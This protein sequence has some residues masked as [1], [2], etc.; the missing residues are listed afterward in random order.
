[1]SSYTI[2]DRDLKRSLNLNIYAITFGMV[3]FTI[4][5][6]PI[7]SPV[8]TG[9]M[10]K[11]GAGDFIYSVVLALP[12][13]GAIS[14]I[15]GS[16]LLET[17]G[18][19]KFV[20]L[21]SGFVHRFLWIPVAI[22]PLLLDGNSHQ[23]MIWSITILITVSS[24]ASSVT[25]VAFN[26]WM[27]AL[28]PPD[29]VGRFFGMRTLISTISGAA[30][31]LIVGLF[32]DRIDNLFGF[33]IVFAVGALFGLMDIIT[34]SFIKHPPMELS[35]DKPSLIKIITEP[36]KNKN[37]LNYVIFATA[38]SFG[39]NFTAPFFNVYMLEDLKMNYFAINLA[40]QVMSSLTTI[41]FVRQWGV[42]A[43]RYGNKPVTFVSGLI[44]ALLPLMW[45]FTSP[46]NITMVF[47]ANIFTGI[48]WSGYNL[49]LFNQS[50]WL[51][52]ERNRSSYIACFTLL[53]SVVGTAAAYVCGGTFMQFGRPFFEKAHIPF[54]MGTTLSAFFIMCI[55]SSILR[56]LALAIFHQLYN[57]ENSKSSKEMLLDIISQLKK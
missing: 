46:S 26:S 17:T 13:L 2:S 28:V 12:L 15:F 37:Y 55:I 5:G 36:F 45:I 54:L 20:F 52:P 22:I 10:R 39:V 31:A 41:L 8:F 21:A 29:I 53:T 9:F 3:F 51:A 7:G 35:N 57:E 25:G 47:A 4:V 48:G 30:T 43:D 27:G 33:A 1:M 38:F 16:Y 56:F 11:L 14:Q 24:V 18:K 44:V 32:V 34:F 49:A 19:R 23:A 40:T 42:L 50:I 6:N